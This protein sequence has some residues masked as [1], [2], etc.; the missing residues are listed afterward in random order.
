MEGPETL[1]EMAAPPPTPHL[2]PQQTPQRRMTTM[3]AAAALGVGL[4]VLALQV[5]TLRATGEVRTEVEAAQADAAAAAGSVETL[6][7][8]VEGL[9]ATLEGIDD[10]L[11]ASSIGGS[12]GTGASS[13][14][15]T[16]EAVQALPPYPTS[17]ADPA[18]QTRMALGEI[19]GN[20]YYSGAPL[21][22]SP[23]GEKATVWLVWA[24][25]CPHCQDELPELSAFWADSAEQFPN[26]DV[27]TITSSIDPTRGNPLEAYLDGS[28]FTF[29][30]LVDQDNELATTMGTTA[31]PF[32]VVTGPD[33]RVLL[34]RP[35]A[36]GLDQMAGLFGSVDAFVSG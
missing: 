1:D 35:G 14:A 9:T 20:E 11:A 27:V 25:W 16:T 36:L 5:A 10:E 24:H 21:T 31:F 26:V 34:R 12:V 6:R 28:G 33:G 7:A 15:E 22:V 13:A 32:W 4:A 17:G 3:L 2:P 8:D 30:V 23:D 19:T 18:V 29:P